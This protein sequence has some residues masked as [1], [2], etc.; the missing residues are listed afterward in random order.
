MVSIF[1]D[2]SDE[3]GSEI[4]AYCPK[5]KADTTHVIISKYE[6]EIRRVQCNPCGDV[7]AFRKPRGEADDEP[8]EPISVKK[9]AAKV[10]PTW[11]Q[12]MAK[13]KKQPRLYV[14][15]EQYAEN[16]LLSHPK[17]GVGFVS[18]VIGLDKIEV[19]FQAEKRVLIHNRKGMSLP[20][21]A[22]AHVVDAT[23]PTGDK[24]KAAV[25]QAAA[26]QAAAKGDS[27]PE[28]AAKPEPAR[29]GDKAKPAKAEPKVAATAK[30]KTAVKPATEKAAKKSD[31]KA[32]KKP[33]KKKSDQKPEQKSEKK[34]EKKKSEQKSEKK[35]EKQKGGKKAAK[36]AEK[37]AKK[38]SRDKKAKSK[39]S[40]R[41]AS[42]ASPGK[43]R[44]SE[45]GRSVARAAAKRPAASS[46]KAR[47]KSAKAAK[48]SRTS[49]R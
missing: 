19:T 35:S 24:R 29:A 9:R 39:G 49:K 20:P 36:K 8:P 27:K 7:H 33:E 4:E 38:E 10:K 30:G 13:A 21:A 44:P 16:E 41:P 14:V 40:A 5:C 25:K 28:K 15:A 43:A 2:D 26:K 6:D 46:T 47:P 32:I 23:L 12:V 1:D 37:K 17:F 45:K 31:E 22:Y 42:K 34:S 11:D 3:V 48:A 18:E